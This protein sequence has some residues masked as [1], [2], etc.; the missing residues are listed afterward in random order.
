M[1][2][3]LLIKHC[4]SARIKGFFHFKREITYYK[5]RQFNPTKILFNYVQILKNILNFHGTNGV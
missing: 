3:L 2:T 1:Q 5:K 4:L